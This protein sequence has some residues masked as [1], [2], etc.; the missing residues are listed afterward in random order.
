[1]TLRRILA[2][3][4]VAVLTA[5]TAS[6]QSRHGDTPRR[7]A[8]ADNIA[9]TLTVTTPESEQARLRKYDTPALSGAWPAT[10]SQALGG[11]LPRPVADF[12]VQSGP[13]LE[14]LSLFSGGLLVVQYSSPDRRF[15]KLILSP[16]AW[17]SLAHSLSAERLSAALSRNSLPRPNGE[18][19]TLRLYRP[20]GTHVES[21]FDSTATLPE[22][23]AEQ[24]E[25]LKSLLSAVASDR[26]LTSMANYEPAAGDELLGHDS[27]VYRVVGVHGDKHIVELRCVNQPTSMF[28]PEKDLL[29]YF[30][31]RREHAQ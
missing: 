30:V 13:S 22:D 18:R 5:A 2:T 11:E 25:P 4:T 29:N 19:T 9:P 8:P 31:G 26:Q 10:G 14:R 28:V 17:E 24:V 27:K 20:D 16:M 21:S 3:M 23:L 6:S 7:K 12:L 1:M 15:R